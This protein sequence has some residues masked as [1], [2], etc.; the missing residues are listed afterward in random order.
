[1][2]EI[3]KKLNSLKSIKPDQNWKI[4][5]RE[6]L[7]S[8]ISN[9]SPEKNSSGNFFLYIK[10]AFLHD[11]S[12]LSQ[13]VAS[14]AVIIF[15]IVGGGFFSISAASEATPGSFLYTAKI[16]GEKT[17]FIFTPNSEEKVKLQVRFAQR[18]VE[19]IGG[20]A[21]GSEHQIIEKIADSLKN[22]ISAMQERLAEIE[23]DNPETAL[24][25]A[26]EIESKTN[27]L[28]QQLKSSRQTIA[29]QS[30]SAESKINEAIRSV[31]KAG[32]S[33]LNTIAR[34]AD[35]NNDKNDINNRVAAKLETAKEK[36]SEVQSDADKVFSAGLGRSEN[37][38]QIYDQSKNDDK[39]QVVENKTNEASMAITEAEELLKNDDYKA[40]IEKINESQVILD[41]ASEKVDESKKE[42]DE[43]IGTSTPQVKGAIEQADETTSEGGAINTEEA[44]AL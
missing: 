10:E 4:S 20:L 23:A 12:F 9:F 44:E 37:G 34:S 25:L 39:K 28:R 40:A 14:M 29:N 35:S 15:L 3:I 8:Q 41:E 43:N 42:A 31:D 24:E 32:L 22:E 11:I 19:E 6:L 1:M 5:Q 27:I 13:P 36:I 33:A 26:K 7:M 2:E 18:R 38:I 17:Q 16:V 21:Y 30:S